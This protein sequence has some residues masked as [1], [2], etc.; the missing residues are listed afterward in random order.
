M[1]GYDKTKKKAVCDRETRGKTFGFVK[2][3]HTA[4]GDSCRL[5][6]AGHNC[7]KPMLL[8]ATASTLL[9]G[10]PRSKSWKFT[11]PNGEVRI[12]TRITEQSEV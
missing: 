12:V 4:A 9:P 2:E 1:L 5:V 6:A 7:K 3:T 11:A 10:T 8:I